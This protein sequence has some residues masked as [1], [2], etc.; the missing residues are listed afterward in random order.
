LEAAF[1]SNM[2]KKKAS[3]GAFHGLTS[4]SF[5]QKKKVV[6]GNVKHSGD[7]IDSRFYYVA[8]SQKYTQKKKEKEKEKKRKERK[9][10]LVLSIAVIKSNW[11]K[12]LIGSRIAFNCL[13]IA[14]YCFSGSGIS[15]FSDIESLS[16]DDEDVS[17]SVDDDGSLLG[18]AM[19]TLKAKCVNSGA[20]FSSPLG[21]PNYIMDKKFFALNINLSAVE[22]KSATA[23]TQYI[24]KIFSKINGFGGATTSSKFEEIIKSMFTSEKSMKKTVLLAGENGI[25]I[26]SDLKKQKIRSDWAIVI[27]EIPIDTSKDMIVTAVAEFGKIKSIKIQLIGLWQKTVV[28]FADSD[29]AVQLALRWSFLIRKDSVFVAM[30]MGDH[31]TWASR[32]QFRVLLF[33][34]PMETTAH[35]LGTLLDRAGGKTCIINQ[36]LNTGNKVCCVVV[37]FKSEEDLDTAFYIEPIFGGVRL[38]W[39]RLDLV[40]C[41]KCGHFGHLILKCNVSVVSSSELSSLF[42]KPASGYNHFWLAKLYAKKK[43][44]ISHPAVFGGKSWAQIVSLNS[45]SGGSLFGSGLLS[46]GPPLSLGSSGPQVNELGEHLVV[47]ERSL[48]ILANQVS[49]IIKKLSFVKLV[50]LVSP[51][52]ASP[53]AVSVPLAPVVDLDMALDGLLAL[54]TPP[55]SSSSGSVDGLNSSSSKVLTSKLGSLESKMSA[56]EALFS[57]IMFVPTSVISM[58][59]LIWKFAMCNHVSSRNMVS[60]V[61][62]TKLRS[63]FGSWIKNKFDEVRIFTS[64]LDIGYLG[65][66]IAVIMDNSLARHVSKVEKVSGYLILIQLLFKGKLLAPAVNSLIAKSVNSSTFVVLAGDFNENDFGRSASF[67]F[68]LDLGLVNSFAGHSLGVEKTIDFI[69]VSETLSSAVVKHCVNSVSDFFNT[70]YKSVMVLVG[71][72]GLLDIRLNDLHKQAN[73]NCWKFRIKNTDGAEWFHFKEYFSAKMLKVKGRFFGTAAGLDLDAMWSLL[74][75]IVVNSADEIFSRH[76]FCDFQCLKN[77]HS[78]KFLGLESLIAKIVKCLISANT[79]G[80]NQFVKKW[81]ALDASK[82]LVMEDM[83]HD[84]QK[85]ENL[86]SYLLLVK[87]E[88]RKSKMFESK[89]LQEATI[90]MAIEKHIE[91]FCLDKGSIIRSVLDW[92]FQKVVLDHLVVDDELILELEEI[93]S[94]LDIEACDAY[95]ARSFSNVISAI[96]MGE[97][98]LVTNGLPDGKAADLSGILNE[99]WKHSC[100][101]MLECLLVLLNVY[102]SV[103]MVSAFW[104]K[105]AKK[106]LSKI[107]SDHISLACSASTQSLVFVV[108]LVVEDALKKNREIW[109]VLQDMWKAYDSVGWPHLRASL[110]CI[111]MCERFIGYFGNIHE[112]RVNRV[113]T[114]FGLSDG[115]S[116]HD[117][118]DQ[119]ERIFYDPLFC[120]V[121]RHKHLCKYHVDSKFVMKM[122]RVEGA[123]TQYALNIASEFFKINDIF[124]NNDKTVA[125]PINQDVRVASLSICGQPISIAKNGKAHHYLGIFLSMESLFK[126]N[127][128]KAHSDV[129]FFVNVV[130]RK[131]ITDKQFSYLV[132]AVLQS[133]VSYQTQFSFV[134]S[135]VCHKWDV[136]VKKGLKSKAG[137]PCDF[138][139]A[140]LYHSSL[141]GLKTFEQVQSEGKIAALVS[142]SNAFE[143]LRCLFDYK[144]IHLQVFGWAPLN[145][146]QFPVKLHV[147]LVN[148]FLAGIMKIFLSNKLSL[149]NNLP[150]A[151]HSPDHSDVFSLVKDELHNIWSSCFK[152]YTNGSL[153]NTG[154]VDAACSVTVYF[155]VLD[156]S[157]GVVV[158]GLLFST[159][160]ELQAVAL[161]FEEKDLEV[162]WVK[163]EGYSGI[164]GN[165]KADL[166]AGKAA[167]SSFSLLTKVHEHYL[168][169]DNTAISGNAC[170]FAESG[171]GVVPVDLIGCIDWISTVKVW[172][173]D[174]HMLAGFTG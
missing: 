154:S 108:G 10:K 57:L 23:K 125:I 24:R 72:S 103:G 169:A 114:N 77:K 137:L 43:V 174:S 87:K 166:V 12:S 84:S 111:K 115:Y 132:S 144:F 86:L 149:A 139:D 29:Q 81:S 123:S 157:V 37:G 9:N 129:C 74:E 130:L 2:S 173:P 13:A 146:L 50:S 164:S 47:L 171:V 110:W 21:S 134:S 31:E 109:L 44:P 147:S 19:N 126:P 88:Y 97:L 25:N 168:V 60:F 128:S 124:I 163:I 93:R 53:L 30:A 107:L 158:G 48:E 46:G 135:G 73:K 55:F 20:N 150:N 58:S 151:F 127:V 153:R 5:M 118:L 99:L 7:V 35:D 102:L 155:L 62:E 18:S 51:S 56:L 90:R 138:L 8:T 121:K 170:Y 75:K 140:A 61:A 142:F 68:C 112:N 105:T 89:L 1:G 54:A 49:V 38:L 16:G 66:G 63:S 28:E 40:K 65:A 98:L 152:V 131:A 106:I 34:L 141:Y 145:L 148:N 116:V 33:T 159:L 76:W 22:D 59:G 113:M 80:F 92:P 122:G 165:V 27:K 101:E 136:M 11:S 32:D 91:Q 161:A 119:S 82:A 143:V 162:V 36:S 70:D 117:R 14:S 160:V 94:R 104:K 96:S 45:S 78:S 4:G 83:V 6:L 71:L 85:I 172:H 167:R 100:G 42:K 69:L 3:K 95:G 52:C 39:T 133:I 120:K 15:M 26:N 41:G 17:M 156:K 67:K 64:G 79:F